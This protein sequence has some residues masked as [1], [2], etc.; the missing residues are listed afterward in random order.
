MTLVPQ[1]VKLVSVS[2]A[3][4]PNMISQREA[5]SVAH[6]SFSARYDDFERLVKVFESS[7]ILKRYLVKPLDWYLQPLVLI[8]TQN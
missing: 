5:A 3:V 6:E 1:Q 2:T 4:P 7:G 8:F